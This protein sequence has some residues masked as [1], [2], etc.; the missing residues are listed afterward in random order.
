MREKNA[1]KSRRAKPPALLRT[2]LLDEHPSPAKMA[3]W[4]GHLP[5]EADDAV[6][7]SHIRPLAAM[8]SREQLEDRARRI[9]R[10]IASWDREKLEADYTRTL[11]SAL[12]LR[13]SQRILGA[14]LPV[15]T[16]MAEQ[17]ASYQELRETARIVVQYANTLLKPELKRRHGYHKGGIEGTAERKHYAVELH[18]R[19]FAAYR[20]YVEEGREPRNA[21]STLAPRW[22]VTPRTFRE[23][24]KKAKERAERAGNK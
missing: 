20:K 13:K 7:V 11:L 9:Q 6:D 23:G 16:T 8:P 21:A 2:P 4:T 15:L 17:R 1:S 24:I 22:N 3:V 19:W 14:L 18:D 10:N 12:L 5:E